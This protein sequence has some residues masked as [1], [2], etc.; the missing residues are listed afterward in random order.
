[1]RAVW[2]A[3]AAV[4]VAASA[5][6]GLLQSS[7]PIAPTM[8]ASLQKLV[9]E[10]GRLAIGVHTA[11]SIGFYGAAVAGVHY[12]VDLVSLLASLPVISPDILASSTDGGQATLASEAA[13]GFLIY[14]AA[15]PIRWPLT[16]GVTTALGKFTDLR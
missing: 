3:A 1:M 6:A 15:A 4:V 16:I 10:Y 8:A 9:N 13:V 12:G 11:N 7:D 2:S 5:E 14:K